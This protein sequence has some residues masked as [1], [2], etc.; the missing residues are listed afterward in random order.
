VISVARI[1]ES[2]AIWLDKPV[3]LVTLAKPESRI[4]ACPRL[5]MKILAGLMSPAMPHY[6]LSMRF[7]KAAQKTILRVISRPILSAKLAAD[8]VLSGQAR[9]DSN[10]VLSGK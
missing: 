3:T 9:H 7:C 10:L 5:A 6:T 2:A 4:L 1:T 8:G